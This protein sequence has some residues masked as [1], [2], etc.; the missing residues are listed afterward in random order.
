M[1]K[2]LN[3]QTEKDIGFERKESPLRSAEIFS[4][5]FYSYEESKEYVF[6]G[7][8]NKTQKDFEIAV[9]ETM[10]ELINYYYKLQLPMEIKDCFKNYK[11]EMNNINNKIKHFGKHTYKS[12]STQNIYE[13]IDYRRRFKELK[14][15]L[16]DFHKS[17]KIDYINID[18][19]DYSLTHV[20]L[21]NIIMPEMR[22]RGFITPNKTIA[23]LPKWG[24]IGRK[25]DEIKV[26]DF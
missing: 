7:L 5:Y 19:I 24:H 11:R 1:F 16:S 17:D 3:L 21:D 8:G 23:Y 4:I 20:G 15:K 12:K 6:L 25:N 14:K 22:K 18:D 13:V 9:K 10:S 26:Y 2:E